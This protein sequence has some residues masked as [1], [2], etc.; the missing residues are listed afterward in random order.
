MKCWKFFS[1]CENRVVWGVW[2]S[3]HFF[4]LVP[5]SVFMFQGSPRTVASVSGNV[6]TL[7]SPRPLSLR[8]EALN[9]HSLLWPP[10]AI[11]L[12]VKKTSGSR[13]VWWLDLYKHT[14]LHK[15]VITQ[16]CHHTLLVRHRRTSLGKSE[17]AH[18]KAS[19]QDFANQRVMSLQLHPS[20]T[21]SMWTPLGTSNNVN[22]LM[23]FRTA[24]NS[25]HLETNQYCTKI[26]LWSK[27]ICVLRFSHLHKNY[28]NLPQH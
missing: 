17:N 6:K 28:N 1:A 21:R 14:S 2:R 25:K 11:P 22:V 16:V 3:C 7:D 24:T 27:S 13:W 10:G 5:H 19:K 26:H 4:K 18:F 23:W 8:S 20:L 9:L 12:V 15:C